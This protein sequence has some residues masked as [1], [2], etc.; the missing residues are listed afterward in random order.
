MAHREILSH[1]PGTFYRHPAPG[2]P[3][4]AKEGDVV[5]AGAVLG[6]I[7]VMKMFNEVQAEAGGRIVRYLV[8]NEAPV[9]AGQPLLVIEG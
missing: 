2:A 1:L 7:E 9:E 8:D 6:L 5:A 4:F 3:P